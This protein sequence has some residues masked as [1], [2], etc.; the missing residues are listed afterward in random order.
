MNANAMTVLLAYAALLAGLAYAGHR[1]QWKNAAVRR[2]LLAASIPFGVAI[3]F[4]GGLWLSGSSSET[5]PDQQAALP[6]PAPVAAQS[7]PAHHYQIREGMD[8]GYSEAIS[9]QAQKSGQVAAKVTMFRYAGQRDGRH[10]VH[11]SDGT[12]FTAIECA[13]PCEVLKIMSFIDQ[14]YLRH[15]VHVERYRNEP[16]SVANAVLDDAL[17]GRLNQYGMERGK[18]RFQV[19]VDEKNGYQEI[20]VKASEKSKPSL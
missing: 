1:T 18:Q 6:R 7:K 13:T 11:T 4:A 10:Q 16:G 17:N 9:E 15:T 20:A 2:G 5:P 8:F 3:V 14:P 19:W 12:T